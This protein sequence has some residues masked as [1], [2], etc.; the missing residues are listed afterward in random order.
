MSTLHSTPL[1]CVR[2][3][4]AKT[5]WSCCRVRWQSPC[6]SSFNDSTLCGRLIVWRSA[7]VCICRT[8]WSPRTHGRVRSGPGIG[9]FPR[10]SYRLTH[11]AVLSDDITF[12][13]NGCN[14]PS[15]V[16]CRRPELPNRCRCIPCATALR[17]TGCKLAP[18]C[19]PC[20]SYWATVMSAGR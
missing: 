11:T 2:A 5:A 19:A 16:P 7:R 10:P 15:S 6:K 3:R 20:K 14:V 18:I 1:L 12:L 13:R 8:H 17:H 4:A 9:C